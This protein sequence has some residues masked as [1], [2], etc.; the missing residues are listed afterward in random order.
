M[1][2]PIAS[3]LIALAV[4]ACVNEKNLG[5]C[6][7]QAIGQGLANAFDQPVDSR[8][9]IVHA[10]DG[11]PDELVASQSLD[12]GF[13]QMVLLSPIVSSS[14]PHQ[15][16]GSCLSSV[17]EF[18]PSPL[19]DGGATGP[20]RAE[21]QL[22]VLDAGT[23]PGQPFLANLTG[24]SFSFEDAGTVGLPDVQFADTLH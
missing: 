15:A 19:P 14:L 6:L 18:F 2:N 5:T 21:G 10:A 23:E 12:G 8:A 3:A 16:A 22:T 9:T 20:F 4:T 11:G 24:L 7:G 13:V 1:R 17:V